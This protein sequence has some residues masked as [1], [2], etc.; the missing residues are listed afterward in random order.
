LS[1][2]PPRSTLFPYRRSSDLIELPR[3]QLLEAAWVLWPL[4]QV[5]GKRRH[6]LLKQTY[7]E[8]WE[9]FVGDRSDIN[10]VDFEWHGRRLS[11]AALD[12]KSTRLNSSHVKISYA[13]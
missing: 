12:R 4:A 5:A 11:H 7:K 9:H 2:P 8:L 10:A 3:P 1:R 13:V 6:P